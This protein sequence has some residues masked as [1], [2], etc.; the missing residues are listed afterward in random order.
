[1][2]EI[3]IDREEENEMT[4]DD[5]YEDETFYKMWEDDRL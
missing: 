5:V 3:N 4:N 1:M 2:L